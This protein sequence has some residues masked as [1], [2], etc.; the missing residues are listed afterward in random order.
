MVPFMKRA[1]KPEA[2]RSEPVP[3]SDCRQATRPCGGQQAEGGGCEASAGGGGAAGC[4]GS[5]SLHHVAVDQGRIADCACCS[6]PC[7]C[8]PVQ[9][10]CY[11]CHVSKQVDPHRAAG[12]HRAGA[13][14][15]AGAY[16]RSSLRRARMP[17]AVHM[18]PPQATQAHMVPPQATTGHAGPHGATTGHA[19][20]HAHTAPTSAMAGWPAPSSSSTVAFRKASRPSIGR[21]S[22]FS[23]RARMR[24]S[25]CRWQEAE[26]GSR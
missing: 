18:V 20:P 5:S 7:C 22:L 24:C 4:A 23:A 6:A 11:P 25:A 1:M 10:V 21:Y 14:R 8:C 3:D 13:H 26:G 12:A 17:A 16:S 15:A 9:H 19:S 2:T